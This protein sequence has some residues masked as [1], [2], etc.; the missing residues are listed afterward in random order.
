[1]RR[2]VLEL[3]D[4]EWRALRGGY[5]V[6]FDPRPALRVVRD[7]G[8][9]AA[10]W[11]ELWEEL[12]HQGD[13]GEASYAALIELSLVSN[14]ERDR[15]QIYSLATC[16]ESERYRLTNPPVPD[17]WKL[18]HEKACERLVASALL[19]L[20]DTRDPRLVRSALAFVALRRGAVELGAF[21][22]WLDES[23]LSAL[24]ED[25]MNWSSLYGS[26]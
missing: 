26:H 4:E 6:A 16:I 21:L 3:S 19:D 15:L 14:S 25:S 12:Y 1:M 7:G 24:L 8:D 13:L 11:T 20:S 10:A 9:A 23:E 17:A 22:G 18:E 5:G 2:R